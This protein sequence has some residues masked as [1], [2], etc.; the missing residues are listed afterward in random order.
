MEENR[1]AILGKVAVAAG[2]G[3]KELDLGVH[4]FCG[5]AGVR[6]FVVAS[7]PGRWRL[8]VFAAVMIGGCREWVAQ[9]P[10]IEKLVGRC[11]IPVMPEV[12]NYCD[13][14]GC[15]RKKEAVTTRRGEP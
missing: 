14:G 11:G 2:I 15:P 1:D 12:G 10:A 13:T 7:N 8:R 3:F 6:C 4:A 9:K 5:G